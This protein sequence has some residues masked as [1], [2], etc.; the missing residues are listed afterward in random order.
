MSD[1]GHRLR[2]RLG[3]LGLL[4]AAS[5][6][7]EH[8][9][10]LLAASD[11]FAEAPAA[12]RIELEAGSEGNAARSRLELFRGGPERAL[13]RFLD[14]GELGRFVLRRDGETWFL[15]PG[16]RPVRIGSSLRLQGGA[17]LDDL[18][19]LSLARDYRIAAFREE[20][21]IA[22]FELEALVA[23]AAVPRLRWVV[24]VATRLPRR[25]DLLRRDGKPLRVIEFRGWLDARRKI[26]GRLAIADLTRRG[27]KLVLD[28][29]ELDA[30]PLDP[31]L[32]ALEGG[33]A[34]G[35]LQLPSTVP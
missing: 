16:A 11:L 21:G 24:E 26:P 33:A 34:R 20:S 17:L 5:L 6:A 12:L 4:A 3:A 19:G 31:E 9:A 32:F 29:L 1:R 13:V 30:G 15:A 7:A 27:P 18:L 28:F 10:D 2:A 23:T 22:T 8:P 25:A 14:A 35:R